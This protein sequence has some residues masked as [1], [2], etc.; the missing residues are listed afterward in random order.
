[1]V[2]TTPCTSVPAPGALVT[3]I[4]ARGAGAIA[5]V[6]QAAGL[7]HV[8]I[9]E[10]APVVADVEDQ[11]CVDLAHLDRR[12][13]C[14]AGVLGGV[15]ERLEAAEVH[16]GLDLGRIA[17]QAGDV[18]RRFDGSAAAGPRERIA[19]PAIDQQRRIDPAHQRAELLQRVLGIGL[20]FVQEP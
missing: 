18:E 1:M 12:V 5:H 11:V 2:G 6:R 19:Q 4:A 20:Q 8:C 16:S 10:P 9:R 15:L 14:L 7:R 17:A 3:S 13:G